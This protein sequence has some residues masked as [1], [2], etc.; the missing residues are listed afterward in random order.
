M[1][2]LFP[3]VVDSPMFLHLMAASRLIV[4]LCAPT[5]DLPVLFHLPAGSSAPRLVPTADSLVSSFPSATEHPSALRVRPNARVNPPFGLLS[6][7]SSP[8]PPAV[9]TV[10]LRPLLE[11]FVLLLAT[12]AMLATTPYPL[13]AAFMTVEQ[14]ADPL[15]QTPNPLGRQAVNAPLVLSMAFVPLFG[16]P[17][18]SQGS[19]RPR[20]VLPGGHPPHVSTKRRSQCSL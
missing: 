7:C 13:L 14:A 6:L 19:F 12:H 9:M 2:I 3:L 8:D 15:L 11:A 16:L 1:M 10:L 5:M 20:T 4:L 18:N 17:V